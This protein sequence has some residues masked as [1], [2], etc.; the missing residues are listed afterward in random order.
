MSTILLDSFATAHMGAITHRVHLALCRRREV[1]DGRAREAR[2][3]ELT[4]A[5]EAAAAR[6]RPRPLTGAACI[7]RLP[8]AHLPDAILAAGT[9]EQGT[10]VRWIG[11][12]PQWGEGVLIEPLPAGTRIEVTRAPR[13]SDPGAVTLTYPEGTPGPLDWASAEDRELDRELSRTEGTA[14]WVG[15]GTTVDAPTAEGNEETEADIDP[16]TARAMIAA[17]VEVFG[18]AVLPGAGGAE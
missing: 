5:W 1:R 6:R 12:A 16:D 17:L 14:D 11:G 8:A 7:A 18:P 13:R 4:P 10:P 15:W 9:L 3:A 2:R